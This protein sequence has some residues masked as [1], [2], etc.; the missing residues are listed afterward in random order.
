M[1]VSFSSGPEADGTERASS[2]PRAEVRADEYADTSL[3]GIS[4]LGALSAARAAGGP[5]ARPRWQRRRWMVGVVWAVVLLAGGAVTVPVVRELQ[6]QYARIATATHASPS[7]SPSSNPP[8]SRPD[9]SPLHPTGK[10]KTNHSASASP[11]SQPPIVTVVGKPNVT[12]HS[13]R[14][15]VPNHVAKINWK[16]PPG[17]LFTGTPQ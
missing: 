6:V 12:G 8:V 7:S 14:R 9:E 5:V 1:Q 4:E 10:T 11:L 17:A 16:H 2:A 15:T 13:I 3:Q